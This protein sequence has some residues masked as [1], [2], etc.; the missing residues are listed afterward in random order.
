MTYKTTICVSNAFT[1]HNDH[2][3]KALLLST[4]LI[5]DS[6]LSVQL[7]A[8]IPMI[9]NKRFVSVVVV[10]AAIPAMVSIDFVY[11]MVTI[12]YLDDVLV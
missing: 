7:A 10:V 5:D 4:T 9:F 12:I 3:E 8:I 1:I 2:F 6:V 11:C